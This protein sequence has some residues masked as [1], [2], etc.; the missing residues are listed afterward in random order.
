M[1]VPA[2]GF[3]MRLDESGSGPVPSD[4]RCGGFQVLFEDD[5]ALVRLLP[6]E[7]HLPDG[8]ASAV[9]QGLSE[10]P[11]LLADALRLAPPP[12]A[13][14]RVEV[15]L[16]SGELTQGE[17]LAVGA[18]SIRIFLGEG[19]RAE[20][21]TRI[22][23]HEAL[24]LLL[25][26]SLR[27]G[28]RWNDPE[29][30]FADWIVR[31]I[32]SGREA[33]VPRF[34]APLPQLVA[35]P[36]SSRAEV[37]KQLASPP[38]AARRYFGDALW[39]E[40]SRVEGEQRKLWLVEAAL[41]AHYLEAACRLDD[42]GAVVLDD[43]LLDYEQYARA[44]GNPPS[45]AG[46]LWQLSDPGWSRDPLVRLSVAAQALQCDD[47][48]FFSGERTEVEPVVWKNRGR[49]RLPLRSAARARADAG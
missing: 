3:Q 24:H 16:Q 13:Y 15:K 26:A 45:G 30:A 34:H 7:R 22:A 32:E 43:W 37:Q 47:H 9:L 21:A 23:R 1:T 41:G 46:H 17:A 38:G 39:L 20:E 5:A 48:C 27:G 33:Q 28:E 44:V 42:L 6:G 2:S 25:S 11:Q 31:G 8:M 49:V 35:R 12:R 29:L 10:A 14:E 36:P 40:L 18:G 19:A 4:A